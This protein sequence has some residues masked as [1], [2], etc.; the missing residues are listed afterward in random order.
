MYLDKRC[1]A[2][3][4]QRLCK[5]GPHWQGFPTSVLDSMYVFIIVNFGRVSI[6][7]RSPEGFP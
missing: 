5:H 3:S 2:E 6:R 7:R 4:S 1:A